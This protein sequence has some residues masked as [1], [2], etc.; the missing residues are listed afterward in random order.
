MQETLERLRDMGFCTEEMGKFKINTL[1]KQCARFPVSPVAGDML[2]LAIEKK[3]V[4]QV[5]LCLM[6]NVIIYVFIYIIFTYFYAVN[7]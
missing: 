3:C 1:G 7:R 4:F 2:A 5:N 6:Y